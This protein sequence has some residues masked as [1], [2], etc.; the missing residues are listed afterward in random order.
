M[1]AFEKFENCYLEIKSILNGKIM[2]EDENCEHIAR[3]CTKSGLI[4]E[5]SVWHKYQNF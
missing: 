3:K 2:A 5:H 1:P 4:K